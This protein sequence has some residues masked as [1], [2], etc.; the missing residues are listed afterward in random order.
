MKPLIMRF[1]MNRAIHIIF[2]V[3]AP[4]VAMLSA[5][6]GS[7][8]AKLQIVGNPEKS[9]TEFVVLTIRDANDRICAAIQTVS[10]M[11]GFSYKSNN[12]VVQVDDKPGKDMVY[13]SPD[14]RVLEIMHSGHEPFKLIL[15]EYGIQLRE[16]E[17]WIVKIA[18][19][20]QTSRIKAPVFPAANQP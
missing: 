14:E 11:D 3:L 7:G 17:V 5:Q 1:F 9:A 13:L 18:G 16:K 10:D 2:S 8:P 15:S 6:T 12:G 20:R 4:A 19:E